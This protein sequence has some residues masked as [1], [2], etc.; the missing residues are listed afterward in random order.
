MSVASPSAPPPTLHL[1]TTHLSSHITGS[2][3]T[4]AWLLSPW[5]A[6]LVG[7]AAVAVL[8][9]LAARWVR[10]HRGRSAAPAWRFRTGQGLLGVGALLLAAL[11]VGA[12]VN[13]YAGYLPTLAAVGRLATG[14]QTGDVSTADADLHAALASSGLIAA[15]PRDARWRTVVVPL[16]DTALHIGNRDIV[17]ALPPGY[18]AQPGV[19]YP[20]VYLF[21]GYPGR[22]TDWFVSGHVTQAVDALVAAR[23]LPFP[24]LVAPDVNGGYL[25]DSEGLDATGGPQ[26]Q[27]WFAHDVVS[28]VD[29]HLRTKADRADRVL[30]GMSSGGYEAVNIA[31]QQQDEFGIGIGLEPYGDPGQVADRLLGGSIAAL[32]A[33]DLNYYVPT[34]PLHRTIEVF[35][36]DGGSSIRSV[37]R[38]GALA[39]LIADRGEPVEMRV[40]PHEG[41]TWAEAAAGLPYAL[42]FVGRHL[43]EPALLQTPPPGTFPLRHRT[44]LSLLLSRDAQRTHTG[45]ARPRPQSP[46]AP[47]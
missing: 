20:V 10:R 17:V 34:F 1:D 4:G 13:S 43:G 28:W 45:R 38:V 35:L 14:D 18:D 23:D 6:A 5:V 33:Q 32:H 30:M 22:A 7:C 41:H 11:T 36:D 42:A 12:A 47:R 25:T 31:F 2:T 16:R 9:L 15:R 27:T 24:I 19:R 44:R 3:R 40:E 46:R 37:G 21:N 26:V 29:G 8:A 39:R